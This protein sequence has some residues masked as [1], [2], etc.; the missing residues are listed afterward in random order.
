VDV[1]DSVAVLILLTFFA[2]GARLMHFD[3]VAVAVILPVVDF[4]FADN[5]APQ[6]TL[7]VVAEDGESGI[8]ASEP[9]ASATVKKRT[10]T[11]RPICCAPLIRQ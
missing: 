10:E 11:F 3:S 6:L 7:L 1:P 8:I 5:S 4:G 9:A 2:V